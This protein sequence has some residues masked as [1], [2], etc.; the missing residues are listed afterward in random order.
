MWRHVHSRRLVRVWE[1]GAAA[2]DIIQSVCVCV[3]VF[4]R[5]RERDRERDRYRDRDRDRAQRQIVPL[6]V[7]AK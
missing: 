5:E 3:C 4:V 2:H 1:E 7:A 6:C